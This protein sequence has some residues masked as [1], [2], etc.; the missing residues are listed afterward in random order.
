MSVNNSKRFVIWTSD[1]FK[2]VQL[3]PTFILYDEGVE[4]ALIN[5]DESVVPIK[6]NLIKSE[7]LSAAYLDKIKRLLLEKKESRKSLI[8]LSDNLDTTRSKL[9]EILEQDNFNKTC[10]S[11]YKSSIS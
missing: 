7:R 3:Y 4:L 10:I 2:K 11:E 9:K 8:N 6:N 1:I 5:E